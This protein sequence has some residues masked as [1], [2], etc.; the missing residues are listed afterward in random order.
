MKRRPRH[1]PNLLL[2]QQLGRREVFL[3]PNL[4]IKSNQPQVT[5][6]SNL[7]K[8]LLLLPLTKNHP[9]LKIPRKK[10]ISRQ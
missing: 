1:L 6:L 8:P 10:K 5:P 2:N 7:T 9:R 4:Q 3:Q